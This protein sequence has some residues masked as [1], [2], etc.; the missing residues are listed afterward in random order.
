MISNGQCLPPDLHLRYIHLFFEDKLSAVNT[1]QLPGS[2]KATRLYT[3][4]WIITKQ[5]YLY[6]SN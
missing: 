4:N 6:Y 5:S 1:V 2:L 3:E